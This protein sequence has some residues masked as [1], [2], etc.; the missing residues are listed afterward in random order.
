MDYGDFVGVGAPPVW[1]PVEQRDGRRGRREQSCPYAVVIEQPEE[2]RQILQAQC[3]V[4]AKDVS[5]T[6]KLGAAIDEWRNSH[7]IQIAAKI[8]V[9]K[10]WTC[11]NDVDC[12]DCTGWRNSFRRRD[13]S[14]RCKARDPCQDNQGRGRYPCRSAH[15]RAGLIRGN[16]LELFSEGRARKIG[17][18]NLRRSA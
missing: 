14:Y 13:A 15:A 10:N 8:V 17:A 3:P 16:F 12:T 18:S 7:K 9:I 6:V 5:L 2:I 11:L 4:M 1:Q